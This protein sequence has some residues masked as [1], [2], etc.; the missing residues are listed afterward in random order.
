VSKVIRDAGWGFPGFTIHT[1]L[2]SSKTF[3]ENLP[4]ISFYV[5]HEMPP[6]LAEGGEILRPIP[7]KITGFL[8]VC[9]ISLQ[10]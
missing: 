6:L 8:A 7:D 4:N 9:T 1:N 3:I 2:A 10:L 5:R